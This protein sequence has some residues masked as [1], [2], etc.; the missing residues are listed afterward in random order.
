VCHVEYERR[1]DNTTHNPD[2]DQILRNIDVGSW[3]AGGRPFYFSLLL[4]DE[5]STPKGTALVDQ[6]RAS[7]DAMRSALSHRPDALPNLKGIGLLRWSDLASVI[8]ECAEG[9]PRGDERAF[10][11]TAIQWLHA[12]GI[13]ATPA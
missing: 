1:Q 8:A 3:Y 6:Y 11:V 2:R 7:P 5:S 4:L 10:A 12:K 13:A 9:A